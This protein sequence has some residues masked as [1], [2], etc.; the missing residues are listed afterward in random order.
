MTPEKK[1]I[2][3]R[4]RSPDNEGMTRAL[5][6]IALALLSPFIYG[7]AYLA[8]LSNFSTFEVHESGGVD[9]PFPRYRFG[10]DVAQTIFAPAHAVDRK[11]RPGRWSTQHRD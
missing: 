1:T 4:R 6:A 10:N 3:N 5:V 2:G 9:G 11:L 8:M 7:G